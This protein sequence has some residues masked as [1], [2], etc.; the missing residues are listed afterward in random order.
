[1]DS[2][3]F[4]AKCSS[5][6]N[7]NTNANANASKGRPLF[8]KFK[9]KVET[10][11]DGLIFIGGAVAALVVVGVLWRICSSNVSLNL[12]MQNVSS[13]PLSAEASGGQQGQKVPKN[14]ENC[15]GGGDGQGLDEWENSSDNFYN[16]PEIS[17]TIGKPIK[18]WDKKRRQWLERHPH[19][20]NYTEGGR[21]RVF[22]VTGSQAKPCRNPIGDHLLLRFFKNKVDYCRLHGLDMFYNTVL[23]QPKM[24]TFW[25]KIPLVRASMLAHPEAEWI[26]WV[27][28]DA[29]ITDM[30][31]EMPLERYANHNLVVHGWEHLVYQKRSWVGLNAGIFLIRNC[32]WSMEFMDRWASMG[33]QSPL[34][35]S[36]GKLLSDTLSD[37]AFKDSDDQSALVYLMIKE[38]EK[39]SNKIFVENSYYLNGYWIEI[40]GTYENITEKYKSMEKDHP[41]L[42]RRHAEKTARVYAEMREAYLRDAGTTE[43]RPFV[44]HFTGCQPCSGDHNKIYEGENCWKGMER[45]LNFADNQ[46]LHNYGF[47]HEDLQS[48]LVSPI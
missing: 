2:P 40:V 14:E 19:V 43:R 18:D 41:I 29:A 9:E 16:D 22:M 13:E 47:I 23:L 24:H 46:V 32:E 45:A 10:L 25:A 3:Q 20:K 28:S 48:S 12:S 27:D 4:M 6:G 5:N 15:Q 8:K 26:W 36:S 44:T 33:P 17:Y 11:N 34:Y 39:W 1:M 21:P 42:N 7:S 30:E 35:V 37:R 38:K 31:F